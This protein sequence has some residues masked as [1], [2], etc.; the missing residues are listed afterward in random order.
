MA[1]IKGEI[2]VLIVD[3]HPLFRQG[4]I[5][6][7]S[8]SDDI[9]V[10]AEASDGDEGLLLIRSL[11]PDVAI[12][13]INLPGINGQ[14]ITQ[15]GV[16]EK[17]PTRFMLLTA[18][19]DREQ[20]LHSAWAGAAG[21]CSKDIEP[22]KLIQAI[23]E[24]NNGNYFL[25]EK[26]LTKPEFEKWIEKQMENAHHLYSEPG[27][28]FHPLSNRE[29]EVLLCV[30]DGKSNKEIAN[31][32]GISHQTVKNH[33]TSILRK[34]AVDD[35]TQAVVYALK[36]GWVQLSDDKINVTEE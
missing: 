13:D 18:Y 14:Q 34:F 33:V 28:P 7:L 10:I 8:T 27:S 16:Q 11:Q 25:E 12:V 17:L 32:L 19:D 31:M 15:Q 26:V 23:H 1:K 22:E 4:V 30:V 21:F 29:M 36:R 20:V 2:S 9:C 5:D 35:R 6:V 24:I 3:D